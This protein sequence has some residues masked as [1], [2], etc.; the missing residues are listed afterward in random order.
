MEELMSK[1]NELLNLETEGDGPTTLKGQVLDAMSFE[2]DNPDEITTFDIICLNILISANFMTPILLQILLIKLS[3]IFLKFQKQ[4]PC[5][6]FDSV[7][8][9]I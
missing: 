1:F 9:G 4:L 5:F 7:S 6:N 3:L 8:K 2:T